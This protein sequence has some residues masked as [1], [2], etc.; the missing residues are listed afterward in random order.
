[1]HLLTTLKYCE[2]FE[3]GFGIGCFRC[4]NG[5]SV[6]KPRPSHQGREYAFEEI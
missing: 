3:M 6:S 5:R 1:M 2:K 4:I